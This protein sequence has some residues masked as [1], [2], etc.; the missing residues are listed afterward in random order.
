MKVTGLAATD[1][2]VARFI[3]SMARSAL[4]KTVELVYSKEDKFNKAVVREFK[5]DITLDPGAEVLTA[6]EQKAESLARAGSTRQAGET[7]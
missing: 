3:A 5:V 6:G 2:E 4:V 7:R 1:V